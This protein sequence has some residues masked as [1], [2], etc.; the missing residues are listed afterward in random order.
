MSTN[1]R[2]FSSGQEYRIWRADNCSKCKKD[3]DWKD[4]PDEGKNLKC[5]AEEALSLAC[6][7]SGRVSKRVAM[8]IGWEKGK[9]S[10]GCPHFERVA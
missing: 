4:Y 8:F 10:W 2:I 5:K 6:V 9:F 7:S 3:Y 1:I